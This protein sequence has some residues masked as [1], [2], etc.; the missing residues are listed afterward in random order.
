[1]PPQAAEADASFFP[2]A[3]LAALLA[4][5]LAAARCVLFAADDETLK[6]ALNCLMSQKRAGTSAETHRYQMKRNASAP[7]SAEG[8]FTSNSSVITKS[9]VKTIMGRPPFLSNSTTSSAT[10][11]HAAARTTH[12]QEFPP[13]VPS[14]SLS[15][16]LG[17][18][19]RAGASA[20][21]VNLSGRQ[22]LNEASQMAP[23]LEKACDVVKIKTRDATSASR[24]AVV[25]Q[26]VGQSVRQLS[27]V[28]DAPRLLHS[29]TAEVSMQPP[30]ASEDHSAV[31]LAPT[32]LNSRGCSSSDRLE[33]AEPRAA[34][35]FSSQIFQCLSPVEEVENASSSFSVDCECDEGGNFPDSTLY[36]LSPLAGQDTAP[37]RVFAGAHHAVSSSP[38]NM[39]LQTASPVSRQ[40]PPVFDAVTGS[41]LIQNMDLIIAD[42]APMQ[43]RIPLYI[44]M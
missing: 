34:K 12:H 10:R 11:F 39:A 36:T 44:F 43:V 30:R 6:C 27:N 42:A 25:K 35:L 4:A 2:C 20:V 29:R 9:G 28:G 17:L 41:T 8:T 32:A 3:P 40:A 15:S 13:T 22:Q 21:Q 19:P 23:R 37:T 1:V 31:G 38:K 33:V 16:A 7:A 5:L 14:Q 18:F 26:S 24:R